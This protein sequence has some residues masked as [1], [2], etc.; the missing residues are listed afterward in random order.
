MS[1]YC[2]RSGVELKLSVDHTDNALRE[3]HPGLT[4]GVLFYPIIDRPYSSNQNFYLLAVYYVHDNTL[5]PG[6]CLRPTIAN[7][8]IFLWEAALI[9]DTSW[10]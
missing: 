8:G 1:I 7:L 10:L 2:Y 4:K 5:I 3:F 9:F 6:P